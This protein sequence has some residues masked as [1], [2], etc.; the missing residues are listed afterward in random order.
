MLKITIRWR[1][2]G[3]RTNYVKGYKEVPGATDEEKGVEGEKDIL[4]EDQIELHIKF[5]KRVD[6]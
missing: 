5:F 2:F 1:K 3:T 6:Y 4:G